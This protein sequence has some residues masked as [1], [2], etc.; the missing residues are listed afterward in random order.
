MN[1]MMLLRGDSAVAAIEAQHAP[2][3]LAQGRIRRERPDLAL[4]ALRDGRV[5]AR[6]S[7]WWTDAPP[8]PEGRAGAIGHFHADDAQGAQTILDAAC[9]AL[10]ES[11]CTTAYGPMDG[12]TWR[13]YRLVV[14]SDGSHPFFLEPSNPPAWPGWWEV[15]GF[16]ESAGYSSSRIALPAPAD[17]RAAAAEARLERSGVRIRTLDASRLEEELRAAYAVTVAAF[18]AAHL[19]TTLPE[20]DFLGRYLALGPALNP[21]YVLLAEK[22]GRLVGYLFAI[23]DLN[24]VRRT[25]ATGTLIGKTIAVLP[26]REFAG[27]GAVLSRRL[28]DIAERAGFRHLIHALQFDGNTSARNL[29]GDGL[30]RLRRYALFAKRLDGRNAS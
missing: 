5:V 27:L 7:C 19:Y 17:P 18:G 21:G 6:A 30:S 22:D 20:S 25:G 2:A 16:S 3:G 4:A 28:Y 8:I 14:E 13:S 10:A 29:S 12:N 11:G 15:A 1:D 23:P 26:G 9:A 24:E